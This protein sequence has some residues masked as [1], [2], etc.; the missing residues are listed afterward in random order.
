MGGELLAGCYRL[1]VFWAEASQPGGKLVSVAQRVSRSA[2]WE[3][4]G[5]HL[6]EARHF[7]R[8][9]RERFGNGARCSDPGATST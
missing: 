6:E 5:R 1:E 8:F 9:Q 7:G 4:P 2:L 3:V